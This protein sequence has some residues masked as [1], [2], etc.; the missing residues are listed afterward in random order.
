MNILGLA[1]FFLEETRGFPKFRASIL[2]SIYSAVILAMFLVADVR[3]VT[4]MD[5]VEDADIDYTFAAIMKISAYLITHSGFLLSTLLFRTK[6]INFLNVL[7]SFNTSI[8]N[9]FTSYSRNVTHIKIQ[10]SVVVSVLTLTAFL[11]SL[12]YDFKGYIQSYRCFVMTVSIVSVNIVTVL[13]INLAVLLK[14]GFTRINTC[15][16]ELI[17]CAGEESV[18]LYRQVSTVEDPQPISEVNYNCVKPMSRILHIRLGCDFV[19]LLNSVFSIDTLV[20]V[21]LYFVMFLYDAYCGIV[22]IMNVKTKLM[23][24]SVEQNAG[25][26]NNVK[27]ATISLESVAS[28]DI[29][30]RH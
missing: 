14:R 29:L 4:R 16:C 9:T 23:F 28:S 18:G 25:E 8:H 11:I 12:G 3:T 27:I 30:E 1:S 19:D 26:N 5:Y 21:M 24:M 10:M 17:Q 20:L 22:G 2:L 13:F 15:L 7:L 6:I